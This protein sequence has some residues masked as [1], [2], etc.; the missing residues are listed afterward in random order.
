MKLIWDDI[1]ER[2]IA[3]HGLTKSDVEEALTDRNRFT[4]RTR[5]RDGL[6]I[7]E[8]KK[9][10]RV[11]GKTRAGDFVVIILGVTLEDKPRV[12]TSYPASKRDVRTYRKRR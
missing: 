6:Q 7:A 8:D 3:E 11:I 4:T 12:V 1:N 9:R 10:Y 2:K 5:Q